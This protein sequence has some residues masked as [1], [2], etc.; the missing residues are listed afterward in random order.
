[1][2]TLSPK[3]ALR[4][5]LV[6]TALRWLPPG[7]IGPVALLLLLDRGL[8]LSEMGMAVAT[9]GIVVFLLELP[10]G[11]L[12]DAIGRRRVVLISMVVSALS[13]ALFAVANSFAAFVVVCALMGIYRALD[14]GPLEAWYVDTVHATDPEAKLEKGLSAQGTVLGVSIAAGSLL[15]SGLVALNPLP[16]L[17]ALVVPALAA[18]AIQL[19]ALAVAWVLMREPAPATGWRAVA[20]SARGTPR[21]IAD[22][23][24]LLRRNRI[25]L[26]LVSVELFWGFGM[27]AFES[28]STVRI[29]E[30]S[31]GLETAATIAGP[32]GMAAWLAGAAGAA[33]TPWLG[34]WIGIAP[35]AGLMRIL[36]GLTVVVMGLSA[37]LV[38]VIAAYIACYIV[39]GT[40]NAAHMTLLHRQVEGRVRATVVSLNSWFSQPSYA[41]GAIVLGAL[42]QQASVST[43]MLVSAVVLA[44]AAPLYVPAWRQSRMDSARAAEPAE[45]VQDGGQALGVD[46]VQAAD[47]TGQGDVKALD[48]A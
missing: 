27:V 39:H 25:L 22:G 40:S 24:G 2:T 31:G 14:S 26:A 42:A 37:G 3:S 17:G 19:V 9:Q 8:T 43:A 20:R 34:R 12:A 15:S 48:P 36:Q 13:L 35:A 46:D 21:T 32:A 5:F 33:L 10:T 38:G 4:R 41:I 6:L 29:A 45:S 44:V 18:L 16:R 47:R 28:L 7:L 23:V 30:I 1:M 11:G